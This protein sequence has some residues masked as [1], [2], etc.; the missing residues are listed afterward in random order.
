MMGKG[1][2]YLSVASNTF[3]GQLFVE[4]KVMYGYIL[5]PGKWNEWLNRLVVHLE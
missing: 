3:D 4:G 5:T 1:S 2:N